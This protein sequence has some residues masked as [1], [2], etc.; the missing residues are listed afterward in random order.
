MDE[1]TGRGVPVKFADR[2]TPAGHLCGE[3]SSALQKSIR[4]GLER[5]ALYWA[6]E[7]D[8][9]GFGD[10]VFKRLKII[11][12]EDVGVAD[13]NVA[14]QVRALY[15]NW[16]D[17][18][19]RAARREDRLRWPR[20]FLVHA[21]ILLVR[22]PKSRLVDHAGMVVYDGDRER[23]EVPDWALDRHTK[24]GRR[25]GRGAAHFFDE[26]AVLAGETLDDPYRD[27][28]RQLKT[29]TSSPQPEQLELGE[30]V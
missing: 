29:R 11:A 23:L 9:A 24:R 14:V 6:S 16:D 19:S 30:E 20:L 13:S 22:A 7:L 2:R 15:E 21:V 27:E 3:A 17:A 10:Y 8:Q 4:R 1:T 5:E 25:M 28:A 18:A 26:G 12:S